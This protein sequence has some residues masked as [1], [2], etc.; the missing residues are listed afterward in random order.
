MAENLCAAYASEYNVNVKS[1][2]LAHTFGPTLDLN[3]SRVFSEFTRN[4]L[5][6]QNIEI[7]SDGNAVRTF[8]YI[9]D[10]TTAFWKVYF[11]GQKG[12]AYNICNNDNFISIKELADKLLELFPDKK[13][14]TV[15]VK[16]SA[17]DNYA[18]DKNANVVKYD[19]SRIRALGWTPNVDVLTAFR[20]TVESFLL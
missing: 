12:A 18:E 19:D 6:G 14:K 8:C 9:S 20:R 5:N 10:A 11:D 15:F 1:V 2:R 4:I 3:D 13:L 17:S 16:R 7:K